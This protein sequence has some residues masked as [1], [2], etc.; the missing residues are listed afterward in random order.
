MWVQLSKIR[1]LYL[2]SARGWIRARRRGPPLASQ[3]P[4]CP[5]VTHNVVTSIPTSATAS[6]SS[7][8]W[9]V[10]PG[11]VLGIRW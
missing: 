4:S 5:G 7:L 6:V 8:F 11:V 2:T 9:V 10:F 1:P 3:L